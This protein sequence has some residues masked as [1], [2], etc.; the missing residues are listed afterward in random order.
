MI[1][2]P[3]D[4]RPCGTIGPWLGR[5]WSRVVRVGPERVLAA[6]V[7]RVGPERVLAADGHQV[8]SA[9]SK[10]VKSTVSGVLDFGSGVSGIQDVIW[11][12]SLRRDR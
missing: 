6:E 11:L 1:G 10:I 3:K 9:R 5:G 4:G 2:V 12:W 8:P 7:V